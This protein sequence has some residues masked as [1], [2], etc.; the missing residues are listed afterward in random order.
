MICGVVSWLNM[1]ISSISC[2]HRTYK[3][4]YVTRG[5]LLVV[6]DSS[7]VVYHSAVAR[8]NNLQAETLSFEITCWRSH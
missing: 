8:R 3:Y 2:S 6:G 7:S 5:P 4:S 1:V